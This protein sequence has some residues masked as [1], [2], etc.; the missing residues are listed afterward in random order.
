MTGHR[1]P[2]GDVF[3]GSSPGTWCSAVGRVILCCCGSG[4]ERR[5]DVGAGGL[6]GVFGGDGGAGSGEGVEA[7]VAAS[8]GPFVVLLGE[9]GAHEADQGVAVGEDADDVGAPPDFAVEAFLGVVRPDL[10][11][12]VAGEHGERQHV[13]ASSVEV[14]GDAR[15]L[16]GE[17]V[18][19][20]VELGVTASASGWS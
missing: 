16:V 12:D 6:L 15:E 1:D 8:F 2:I 11:P 17:G 20:P 9:D 4:A 3:D 18:E 14:V 13:A 19:D 7:E 10:A 5:D